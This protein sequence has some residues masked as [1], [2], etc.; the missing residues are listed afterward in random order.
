LQNVQ[1]SADQHQDEDEDNTPYQTCQK[2]G[3]TKPRIQNNLA[4][5]GFL[6]RIWL[7][8]HDAAPLRLK[9]LNAAL[10]PQ[11]AAGCY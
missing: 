4:A 2:D 9:N 7:L 8:L 11:T 10:V 1:G 5:A 6:C 3:T